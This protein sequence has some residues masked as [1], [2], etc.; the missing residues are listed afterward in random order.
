MK[1]RDGGKLFSAFGFTQLVMIVVIGVALYFAYAPWRWANVR[2]DLHA[3]YPS[4]NP[5]MDYI[6]GPTLER[7]LRDWKTDGA[8]QGPIILDV[9][10][11]AEFNVSHLPS[12]RNVRPGLTPEQMQLLSS[13]EKRAEEFTRAVVVYCSVGYQ[14]AEIVDGLKRLGFTRAQ[15][16]GGG[17]FG[18]AN[19][20]R[21]LVDLSGRAV[22]TVHPGSSEYS[23]IL[24][25]SVRAKVP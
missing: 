13:P 5:D 1:K 10:S 2:E 9:R 3:K 22:T 8:R 12:A 7:W 18:W 20:R 16:L 14:S 21:D 6:N 15:V 19:E 11:E 25:R 17:M 4:L 23:D 24:N